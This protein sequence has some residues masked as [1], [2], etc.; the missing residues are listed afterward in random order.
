MNGYKIT[1]GDRIIKTIRITKINNKSFLVAKE[2]G[3][4]KYS[5]ELYDTRHEAEQI[6]KGMLDSEVVNDKDRILEILY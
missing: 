5:G 4:E 3:K 1:Q 2:G 6:V